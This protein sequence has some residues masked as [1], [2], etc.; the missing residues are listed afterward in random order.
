LN[1]LNLSDNIPDHE[2]LQEYVINCISMDA[3]QSLY[4]DIE[5]E[6]GTITIPERAISVNKRRPLSKNTH[7]MLTSKEAKQLKYDPRI[8]NIQNAN[9]IRSSIKMSAYSQTGTF[10]KTPPASTITSAYKNWALLR[11]IE[12]VKRSDWGDDTGTYT[13]SSTINIDPTGKDVDVIIIDGISPVPDHPEFA[14]YSNGT[15]GSRYVQY[16]WYQLN[17]IVD[18]YPNNTSYYSYDDSAEPNSKLYKNH[19]THVTGIVAGNT[20]GWARD[21]NIYQLSP[22]GF[23][24]IDPLII[25]DYIR[26]FHSSKAINPTTGRKNPT[27][28]NCSYEYV[29][30]SEYLLN[31]GFGNPIFVRVRDVGIGETTLVDGLPEIVGRAMSQEELTRSGIFNTPYSN[32]NVVPPEIGSPYFVLPY[33]DEGIASDVTQALNDGIIIVGAAGNQSFFIDNLNGTDYNN[34]LYFG[35]VDEQTSFL[36]QTVSIPYHKGSAPSSVAGVISVGAISA[37]STEK[38]AS[39]T[40]KGPRVDVFAPGDWIISSVANSTGIATNGSTAT[41]SRNGSFYF[42]RNHGT[43]SA[44]AQVTGILTCLLEIFPSMNS[45]NALNLLNN[46]VSNYQIPQDSNDIYYSDAPLSNTSPTYFSDRISNTNYLM[47][48]KNKYLALRKQR[49]TTGEIYPPETYLLRP[50]TGILYPRTNIRIV[51]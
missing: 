25:W 4:D 49:P 10:S 30:S 32:Y 18:N 20:N 46:Y 39:Y 19:G 43:S 31:G 47:G 34:E 40:N 41:D 33:Y 2:G 35:F 9:F 16:N 12:G 7:Y 6:G 38:I 14:K 42:G 27:I 44:A 24:E 13:K 28:C 5:T 22:Y 15:G 3:L 8:V 36:N 23:G 45:T 48:A 50:D 29:F 1:I 51:T 11:C 37:D 21:A 17:A 26:A